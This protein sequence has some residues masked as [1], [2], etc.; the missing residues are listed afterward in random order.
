MARTIIRYSFD[1]EEGKA[2]RTDIRKRLNAN[3]SNARFSAT[4]HGQLGDLG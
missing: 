4:R 3:A 1:R 2:T